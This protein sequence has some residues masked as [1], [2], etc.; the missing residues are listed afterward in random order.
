MFIIQD[1][2][3]T[4]FCLF[5]QI[6]FTLFAFFYLKIINRTQVVN[7][8]EVEQINRDNDVLLRNGERIPI[9]IRKKEKLIEMLEK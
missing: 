5:V 2:K 8:N 3:Y 1:F 6:L 9:S 7:I 4:N